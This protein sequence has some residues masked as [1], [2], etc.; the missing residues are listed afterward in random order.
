M[1]TRLFKSSLLAGGL[2]LCAG[3]FYSIA[4]EPATTKPSVQAPPVEVPPHPTRK[5]QVAVLLDVSNSMDGLIEQTKAQLWNMVSV[6]GRGNCD[7]Y[8]PKIELALYEYG[9][10]SNKPSA[11]YVEQITPFTTDLDEVSRQLFRLSTLGGDEYCGQVMYTSLNDLKWEDG[12]GHYKVIFIAGNEDFLQGTVPF[13]KACSLAKQK[14]VVVNTIYCGDRQQ[15]LREHWDLGAEC[16]NGSYS[17][18]NSNAAIDLIATPYDDRLFEL[19]KKLNTTYVGFG[20][21]GVESKAKQEE[22]D[23]QNFKMSKEVAADRV[24]VKSKKALYDN[25]G[26][27]LV[28]AQSADPK[29]YQKVDKSKLPEP[30]RTKSSEEL[31]QHIASLAAQRNQV[32][33]EIEVVQKKREEFIHTE[34]TK[35]TGTGDPT[36][37][38]EIEKII[39]SQAGRLG[40]KIE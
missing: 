13:T 38:T 21:R 30:L 31:K 1:P 22:A 37:A 10:S 14:Q 6:L 32:Q 24:A 20:S 23:V 16:G 29:F 26:W 33:Q 9:R 4:K 15:G 40:I 36:L 28:D 8:T 12:P 3:V 34:K 2:L 19:N 17:H 7:G 5:I 25:T 35:K 27:D 39:R 11:G 18:I